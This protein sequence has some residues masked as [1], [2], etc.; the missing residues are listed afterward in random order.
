MLSLIMY[1]L[2]VYIVFKGVEIFQ[3]ALMSNRQDRTF[4]LI[5][6]ILAIAGSVAAAGFFGY[7]TLTS[8]LESY[9]RL[10]ELPKLP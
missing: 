9:R 5:V 4:G 7:V 6:G 1:F 2:C 8:D 3:I 10:Q